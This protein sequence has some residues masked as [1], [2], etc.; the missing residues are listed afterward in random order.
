MAH[1]LAPAEPV[2]AGQAAELPSPTYCARIAYSGPSEG[3]LI[4]AASEGFL[5]ELASSILGVEPEEVDPDQHGKDAIKELANIL[6]GSAVL[7]LGGAECHYSL[8]LPE[9]IECSEAPEPG[10]QGA[11]CFVETEGEILKVIWHPS[12][13]SRSAAA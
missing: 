1:S 6:G 12:D 11:V 9:L 7:E 5:R 13:S 2:D 8:N 10:A 3:Q 4:L